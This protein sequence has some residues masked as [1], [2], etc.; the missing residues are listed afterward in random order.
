MGAQVVDMSILDRRGA[1][2]RQNICINQTY[3]TL[4]QFVWQCGNL[5][6]LPSAFEVKLKVLSEISGSMLIGARSE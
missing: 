4:E 1:R 6:I 3:L 5:W 2:G